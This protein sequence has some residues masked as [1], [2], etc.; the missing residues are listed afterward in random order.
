MLLRNEV[1]LALPPTVPFSHWRDRSVAAPWWDSAAVR[2][3]GALAADASAAG[4]RAW[5]WAWDD[6]GTALLW[7]FDLSGGSSSTPPEPPK[8]AADGLECVARGAWTAEA[9]GDAALDA[10]LLAALQRLLKGAIARAAAT[11]YVPLGDIL[12][13]EPEETLCDRDGVAA[14]RGARIAV[15]R[16]GREVRVRLTAVCLALRAYQVGDVDVLVA[17]TGLRGKAK[18]MR[19]PKGSTER[20]ADA[21]AVELGHVTCWVPRAQ[22]FV[23]DPTLHASHGANVRLLAPDHPVDVWDMRDGRFMPTPGHR[24]T[25]E[26]DREAQR[27]AAALAAEPSPTAMPAAQP[28]GARR[29]ATAG[30]DGEGVFG[31]PLAR[32]VSQTVSHYEESPQMDLSMGIPGDVDMADVSTTPAVRSTYDTN[33]YNMAANGQPAA[34][35]G[36]P[37]AMSG[38]STPAASGGPM[39]PVSD[40]S[41][42]AGEDPMMMGDDE[43]VDAIFDDFFADTAVIDSPAPA[44]AIVPGALELMPPARPAIVLERNMDGF[45]DDDD[46]RKTPESVAIGKQRHA[47]L[48]TTNYRPMQ[49]AA[50]GNRPQTAWHYQPSDGKRTRCESAPV[51]S[52]K[53]PTVDEETVSDG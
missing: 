34:G 27:R 24:W 49:I 23:W 50:S 6:D 46:M 22:V 14:R 42:G 52:S 26:E 43:D 48:V 41:M 16:V 40:P 31:S 29:V 17:P 9:A 38:P 7:L 28:T 47:A 39:W 3:A 13:G 11:H 36:T 4:R 35:S 5:A 15:R 33:D 12:V 45:L 32:A 25:T 19:P 1:A 51:Y 21:V 18:V 20:G 53:R 44:P 10:A 2:V 37:T 8:D 30:S